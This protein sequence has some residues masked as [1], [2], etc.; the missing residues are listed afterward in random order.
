MIMHKTICS[1]L[2]LV[3]VF[4]HEARSETMVINQLVDTIIKE[5]A[6][7]IET[8]VPIPQL[9]KVFHVGFL[10]LGLN[11][12]AGGFSDLSTIKRTADA[13]MELGEEAIT[14]SLP[15]CLESMKIEFSVCEVWLD[16]SSVTDKLTVT[17]GKNAIQAS[18]SV[19]SEDESCQ[20]VVQSAELTLLDDI[21]ISMKK[22]GEE[23]MVSEKLINWILEHFNNK[24]RAAVEL[25]LMAALTSEIEKINL[26]EYI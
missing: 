19:V 17:I 25:K 12:T 1:V 22:L 8:D 24:V 2:F 7:K 6:K 20:I 5:V 10:E 26:C 3:F 21:G 18:I 14:V 4:C 15:L 11:A 13:T 23:E 9:E 16:D